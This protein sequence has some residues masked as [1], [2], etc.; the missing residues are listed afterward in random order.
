MYL[1]VCLLLLILLLFVVI[2]DIVIWYYFCDLLLYLPLLY[3]LLFLFLLLFVVMLHFYF[4]FTIFL[5]FFVAFVDFDSFRCYILLLFVVISKLACEIATLHMFFGGPMYVRM[6]SQMSPEVLQH[7]FRYL[8]GNPLNLL[9]LHPILVSTSI[10]VLLCPG[11]LGFRL[12][13][14]C[15]W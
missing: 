2:V 9:H 11:H 13:Y 4:C 15:R 14:L 8:H 12:P 3:P 7:S 10:I 6:P 5:D 1:F